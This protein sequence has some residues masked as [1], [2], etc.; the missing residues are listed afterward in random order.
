[1]LT[2][3]ELLLLNATVNLYT[4][5]HQSRNVLQDDLEY[6]INLVVLKILA[7]PLTAIVGSGCN[8]ASNS[9]PHSDIRRK[10]RKQRNAANRKQ[11]ETLGEHNSS[12]QTL[13]VV[14][15]KRVE[16]VECCKSMSSLPTPL[17]QLNEVVAY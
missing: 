14:N 13:T 16:E 12:T 11:A 17:Y 6:N 1:M 15:N 3:N 9:F 2:V 8:G 4:Y 10:Q 7:S 5:S